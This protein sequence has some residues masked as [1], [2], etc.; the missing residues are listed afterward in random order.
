MSIKPL[1]LQGTAARAVLMIALLLWGGVFVREKETNERAHIGPGPVSIVHVPATFARRSGDFTANII[2]TYAS[3]VRAIYYTLNDGPPTEVARGR[4][5]L[6][7][8]YFA[9]EL[10]ADEL[11]PATNI[12]TIEAVP[13]IGT[14]K[15]H[16]LTF[17]YDPGPVALPIQ[18][19]WSPA[20]DLDSGDG[21]WETVQLGGEWRVRPRPGY[22]GYDRIL[23]VAG[24]FPE[25]RRV[26]T[27]VIFRWT[28]TPHDFGF[29]ILPMWGGR[30]EKPGL[31]PRNGW[32]FS[33][34]WYWSRYRG[35][36]NEFS[37]RLGSDPY[38][39]VSSYQNRTLLPNVRYRIVAESWPERDSRGKLLAYHQRMKWWPEGEPEPA[40][41]LQL[42]DREGAPLPEGAFGVGLLTLNSQVD[43]G[44]V[45]ITSLNALPE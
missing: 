30:P 26:E 27:D 18:H 42:T 38:E 34:V 36:G 13:F 9:I 37:Y 14:A 15:Q 2:G 5:R 39:W 33:L 8:P 4:P 17:Q 20:S 40:A 3:H 24:A 45:T 31:S 11:R 32:N 16:Q 41:W 19:Q 25:G 28:T 6:P 10:H 7:P 44:P 1:Q 29:G 21:V 35:V 22:E 43:F 12:V 23:V